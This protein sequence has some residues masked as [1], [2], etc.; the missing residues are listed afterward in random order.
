MKIPIRPR[1]GVQGEFF[2]GSNLGTFFGGIGQGVDVGT[3]A[4][5]GSRDPIRSTGGWFDVWFDWTADLHS[6]AGYS[7]DDPFNEDVTV[8]RTYNAFVF[9]NVTYD[10]TKQ[11]LVGL[12]VTFWKTLWVN[13]LPGESV[14]TSAVVKYSF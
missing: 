5:P 12:E 4:F 6:H 10:L 2:T 11:F 14:S 7:I 13:A 8:G 3:P 9:G 1:F